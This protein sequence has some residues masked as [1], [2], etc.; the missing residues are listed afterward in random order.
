MSHVATEIYIEKQTAVQ[1][2]LRQIEAQVGDHAL[3][4]ADDPGNW[5]F[6]GDLGHVEEK[7]KEVR[8]FLLPAG[9]DDDHDTD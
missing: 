2:L 5:G 1:T 8:G 9:E 4:H 7:L 6:I 3:Q